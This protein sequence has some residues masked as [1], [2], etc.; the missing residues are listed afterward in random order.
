MIEDELSED[1]IFRLNLDFSSSL[2]DAI[3]VRQGVDFKCCE[4]CSGVD[5]VNIG[6]FAEITSF[7]CVNCGQR[8][9]AWD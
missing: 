1:S 5:F 3:T 2:R 9:H 6:G 4:R 7:K 8:Y